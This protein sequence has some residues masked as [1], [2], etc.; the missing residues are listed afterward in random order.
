MKDQ[1]R[2]KEGRQGYEPEALNPRSETVEKLWSGYFRAP[3]YLS[4]LPADRWL[5]SGHDPRGSAP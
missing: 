1:Q 3:R 5:S 2:T 4:S